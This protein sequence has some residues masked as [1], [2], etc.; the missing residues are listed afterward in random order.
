MEVPQLFSLDDGWY[1]LF[2]S[3][4]QTQGDARRHGGAGTGT[5][6]L[7]ADDPLGP[8]VLGGSGVLQADEAG[9][10]YAGKVVDGPTGPLFLAWH[11]ID[12]TGRFIGALTDPMP[13][14]VSPDGSL[15]VA[16]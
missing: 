1:M 6:Y 11:Q 4:T 10:T 14:T 15:E 8:F 7:R 9:S 5:Y 13:V 3:D 12:P 16:A 2:A